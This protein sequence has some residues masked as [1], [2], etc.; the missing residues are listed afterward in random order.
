MQTLDII[1]V[2]LW[3]IL[4]SLAN[5]ALI[6]WFAKKFLFAPIRAVFQKR[7]DEIA[8]RYAPL[9]MLSAAQT[10]IA[11]LGRASCR[12]LMLRQLASSPRQRI[13][14]STVPSRS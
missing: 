2:N 14:L 9:T 8:H 3:H 1:S 6:F 13:R 10:R 4:I 12:A 11:R 7:E 5:L